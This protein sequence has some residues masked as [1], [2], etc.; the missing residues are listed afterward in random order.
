MNAKPTPNPRV[1]AT[2]TILPLELE[3]V[4]AFFAKAQN[5]ERIT[6]PE[7]S[8][9]LVSPA[10]L[11]IG[12]GTVIDYRL[13]LWGIP[14]H[15]RSLI[16]HWNPPHTFVDEQIEGP[17]N[18]WHHTHTFTPVYGG[19]KIEDR[20]LYRLPL[21]PVGELAWPLIGLHLRRIFSY[22]ERIIRA[23]LAP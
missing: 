20:V 13:R 4:F 22:R 10:P 21:W 2:S 15:W 3:V 12:K 6:P 14:F 17:Y 8:F 18:L 19:T 11:E 1:L 23:L 16:S 7:L 9:H 5:L